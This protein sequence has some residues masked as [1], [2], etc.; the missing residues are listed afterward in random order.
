[1]DGTEMM[2]FMLQSSKHEHCN[3]KKQI[4]LFSSNFVL[5]HQ[6]EF[7]F[8]ILWLVAAVIDIDCN[9]NYP[10]VSPRKLYL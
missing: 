5:M 3:L 8:T 6:K 10:C 2:L 9:R 4:D 7:F 1:M